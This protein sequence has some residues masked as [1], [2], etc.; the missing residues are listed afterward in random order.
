VLLVASVGLGVFVANS[1]GR[2]DPGESSSGDI[3][4]TSRD[5]LLQAASL[6]SA[7]PPDYRGAIELYDEVLAGQPA[8]TE[9]LT[10]KA[11]LLFQ[12]SRAT[13]DPADTQLLL[14]RANELLDQAVEIDPAYGDARVFRASVLDS[15]GRYADALADLDAVRPGSI[16]ADMSG[17]VDRLRSRIQGE[18]DTA[19]TGPGAS[20]ATTVVTATP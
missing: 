13:E 19:G 15:Q 3:R 14:G 7:D 12:T 17:L 1:S 9:A 10:Y 11:W 20:S 2:R 6:A 8:N 4:Q 18:L 16:P 5:L